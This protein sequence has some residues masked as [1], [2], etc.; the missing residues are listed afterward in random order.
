LAGGRGA[1]G[2][3]FA[4][5]F[6]AGPAA[7]AVEPCSLAGSVVDGRTGGP[8]ANAR[9]TLETSG[10]R[11]LPHAVSVSD[12][13]G[14][15]AMAGVSPGVYKLKAARNGYLDSYHGARRPGAAGT[16]L[17]LEPGCELM[18]LTVR[19]DPFA[20][21]AG[22]VRDA[23]GEPVIEG[24]VEISRFAYLESGEKRF[25][26]V[27]SAITDDLGRYRF[28]GLTPGRYY[29]RAEPKVWPPPE[30][31]A[32]ATYVGAPEFSI[33]AF[34]PGALTAASA[35]GIDVAAGDRISGMDIALPN[36]R[37]FSVLGQVAFPA[38]T[39]PDIALAQLLSQQPLRTQASTAVP[40]NGKFVFPGVPPG[41]YQLRGC[42]VSGEIAAL[43]LHFNR[44]RAFQ[45]CELQIRF[46]V[47]QKSSAR[48]IRV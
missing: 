48:G 36:S 26:T 33:P 44:G 8:V 11:R 3:F 31:D 10:Q 24:R 19:L 34:Y 38:G 20:V 28:I 35:A 25:E 18:G 2:L 14:I 29:V 47:H 16:T 6:L 22:T 21:I 23:D 1:L 13:Q 4:A 30:P 42:F 7:R 27:K 37:L 39:A 17:T 32:P 43:A 41:S 45:V 12:A 15:F 5:G 40:A 46:P 9:V